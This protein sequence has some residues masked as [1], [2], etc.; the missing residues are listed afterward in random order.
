MHNNIALFVP[1]PCYPCGQ[2]PLPC[3]QQ[4][5]ISNAVLGIASRELSARTKPLTSP[6]TPMFNYLSSRA[7]GQAVL[8]I[9]LHVLAVFQLYAP[10]KITRSIVKLSSY[11]TVS[12]KLLLD[13]R[14][15]YFEGAP[16]NFLQASI[17]VR[18]RT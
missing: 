16:F 5:V 15:V 8:L 2:L 14:S 11:D 10:C 6:L 13:V 9:G 3:G 17:V 1:L 12:S 4:G 18:W 7:G